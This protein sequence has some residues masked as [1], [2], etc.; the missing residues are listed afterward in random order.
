MRSFKDGSP[1]GFF[2]TGVLISAVTAF[3][4]KVF[5]GRAYLTLNLFA[6][7]VGVTRTLPVRAIEDLSGNVECFVGFLRQM[8]AVQVVDVRLDQ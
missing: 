6:N 4:D 3:D 1:R 7:E 8:V 2:I 5:N